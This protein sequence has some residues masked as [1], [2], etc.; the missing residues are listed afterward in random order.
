M[1]MYRNIYE[2]VLNYLVSTLV[3]TVIV[4]ESLT[5]TMEDLVI[6]TGMQQTCNTICRGSQSNSRDSL[7]V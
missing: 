1:E 2:H 3:K 4:L 6:D 5:G 7:L